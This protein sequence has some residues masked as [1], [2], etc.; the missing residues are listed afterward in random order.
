LRMGRNKGIRKNN[1]RLC[2]DFWIRVLYFTI[3]LQDYKTIN[4]KRARNEEI[5]S[6]M[7]FKSEEI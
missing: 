1:A 4:Y 6:R 5:K 3:Q 2:K 7:G